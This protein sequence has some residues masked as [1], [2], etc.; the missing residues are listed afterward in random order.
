MVIDLKFVGKSTTRIDGVDKVSGRAKYAYDLQIGESLIG[1]IIRSPIAHAIIKNIRGLEEASELPGVRAV[2]S[3][4][5]LPDVLYG[6]FIADS[7]VLAR[8]RVRYVGEPVVAIAADDIFAA[9][10]AAALIEVE[11]EAIRP[12]DN[13][14]DAMRRDQQLLVHPNFPGYTKTIRDPISLGGK[15]P[16]VSAYLKVRAGDYDS[17]I[18]TADFVVENTFGNVRAHHTH[19]EPVAILAKPGGDHT[20][21]VWTSSRGAFPIRSELSD[22]LSIPEQEIRVI[23]PPNVGGAFGN[24]AS[25]TGEAIAGAMALKSGKPVKLQFTREETFGS[26]TVR[27][28]CAIRI[29]DGVKKSGEIIAREVNLVADGGAYSGGNGPLI[30]KNAIFFI[31]SIYRLPNLKLDAYRVYTNHPPAGSFRGF[32]AEVHWAIECQMD[33]IARKL[34]ISPVDIRLRNIIGEGEKTAIGERLHGVNYR[35]L[36]ERVAKEV[37]SAEY[38]ESTPGWKKGVGFALGEKTTG[39]SPSEVEV[40][41]IPGGHISVRTG[42]VDVGGGIYTTLAQIVGEEFDIEPSSIEFVVADTSLTP[43]DGGANSSRQVY[44]AGNA[45]RLACAEVQN[46]LI[47]TVAQSLS[48]PLEDLTFESGQIRDRAG[49]MKFLHWK[50]LIMEEIVG[51]G[52]WQQKFAE[53]HPDTGLADGER[54]AAYVT[55]SAAAAVVETNME[56]GH[57]RVQKVVV[58]AD[59]GKAI[60]PPMVEGQLEGSIV[61]ALSTALYE[62]LV[63]NEGTI[64]NDDFTDYKLVGSLDAPQL[65][66]ILVESDQEDG[67]YGARGC[68]E[69]A[70]SPISPAIGNA[71]A[72]ST[73]TR[74]T[75]LPITAEKVLEMAMSNK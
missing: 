42:S 75:N 54:A 51:R 69:C 66:C 9:E 12:L 43:K 36:L 53:L 20:L 31:T 5:D 41:F 35:H 38:D 23:V 32:G 2:I 44:H 74:I 50:E 64:L 14:A 60:N 3:A 46:K 52:K 22:A 67:P 26:T 39:G 73:G 61:M 18:S 21:T 17:A 4:K 16:N 59:V 29:R 11:Y 47:K 10:D 49:K 7:R 56:T 63:S 71:I 25:L 15:A 8:E 62:E 65:K 34:G 72:G 70:V 28:P 27:H 13:P 68:G 19:L 58:A 57:I 6:R 30:A 33:I 45:T 55:P 1:K 24:K 48:L 40:R 37:G